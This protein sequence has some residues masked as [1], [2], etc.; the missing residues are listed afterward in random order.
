MVNNSLYI[1]SHT[2]LIYNI[3]GLNIKNCVELIERLTPFFYHLSR[4]YLRKN[5]GCQLLFKADVYFPH[6]NDFFLKIMRIN[7]S[8]VNESCICGTWSRSAIEWLKHWKNY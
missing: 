3:D 2:K 6:M 7:I 5:G 4:I 8:F 1:D